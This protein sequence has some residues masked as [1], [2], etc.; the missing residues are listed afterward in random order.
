M[1]FDLGQLPCPRCG[2]HELRVSQTF[3]AETTEVMT[4]VKVTPA[5]MIITTEAPIGYG[6]SFDAENRYHLDC[7]GCYLNL[8]ECLSHEELRAKLVDMWNDR[9][10][11]RYALQS[12]DGQPPLPIIQGA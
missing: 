3:V 12:Q 11:A 5:H 10:K 6:A 2:K 9:T 1:T 4:E 7:G 8:G